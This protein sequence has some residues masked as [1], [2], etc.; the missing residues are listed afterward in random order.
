MKRFEVFRKGTNP[1]KD[2]KRYSSAVAEFVERLPVGPVYEWKRRGQDAWKQ[3]PGKPLLKGELLDRKLA[4]GDAF[5]ARRKGG[6]A[7]FVLRAIEVVVVPECPVID[8]TPAIK[9]LWDDTYLAFL[10]LGPGYEFVYMGGFVCRK[11]DGSSS[12]S[13]HAFHNAFDVR[14]R[15]AGA[16]NDTIDVAATSKVVQAVKDKAAEALW[17]VASH[18]YHAHLTGDPKRS[19]TPECA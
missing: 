8:P 16:D 11:I 15:K 7:I 10:A 6:T 13:Q 2:I 3:C 12:W 4:V 17:Q 14:I 19:G 5:Y 18:F 1:G 9:A